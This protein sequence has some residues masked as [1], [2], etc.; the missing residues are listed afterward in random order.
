MPSLATDLLSLV[1]LL[2]E[3]ILFA[4]LLLDSILLHE[5]IE[6]LVV[7]FTLVF[8]V[9]V[10]AVLD[11]YLDVFV[12]DSISW[13]HTR[14]DMLILIV[15][16]AHAF[17]L[18]HVRLL[19]LRVIVVVHV[20]VIVLLLELAAFSL[21]RCHHARDLF[22]KLE[23]VDAMLGVAADYFIAFDV[24]KVVLEYVL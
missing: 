24:A 14:Q 1:V 3:I 12:V 6:L 10:P 17:D 4:V 5:L 22:R 11:I 16:I 7:K 2:V 13:Q 23:Q 9:V 19:S 8:V 18:L 20:L 21:R 15:T